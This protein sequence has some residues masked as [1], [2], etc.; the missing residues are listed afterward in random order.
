MQT[1]LCCNIEGLMVRKKRHKIKMIEE[2]G[3]EYNT[4]VICITESHLRNNIQDAEVTIQGYES[5][6]AD[7]IEG[8]KKGGVIVYIRK[9]IAESAIMLVAGSN[10]EVEYVIV[11]IKVWNMI[12]ATVYRPPRCSTNNMLEVIRIIETEVRKLGNPE[13]TIVINGDFNLRTIQWNEQIIYG[14]TLGDRTQANA[15]FSMMENFMLKQMI[16]LPTRGRS[17]LDIFLTNNEDIISNTRVEDTEISDHRLVVL[18][19]TLRVGRS[20]KKPATSVDNYRSLNFFH[21]GIDWE[22]INREIRNTDWHKEMEGKTSNDMYQLF[23]TRILNICLANIPKKKQP[24]RYSIPRDRRILIRKRTKMNRRLQERGDNATKQKLAG[25]ERDMAKSYQK[26]AETEEQKAVSN[27]RRNPKYFFKYAKKKACTHT[28]IGPLNYNGSLTSDPQIMSEALN[29]QY[30][31]TFSGATGEPVNQWSTTTPPTHTQTNDVNFERTDIE[32]AIKEINMYAA[33][34]P[35]GVPPVLL[36][37]SAST[38]S[39]PLHMIWRKSLDTGEI[40]KLLKHGLITPI[41]KSGPK[42]EPKNYRPVALTSHIIKI[43]ER[44]LVKQLT[45]YLSEHSLYN[46]GQHGFRSGRSCVSQLL[47]HRMN[48][49]RALEE[50]EGADVIYLDFSKAFDK[51]KHSILMKKLEHIGI[52]GN[53]HKWIENFFTERS[54]SVIVEGCQSKQS[55]VRSGVAQGSVIG[56]LLFLIYIS[57]IDHTIQYC[58]TTSFADDTRLMGIIRSEEDYGRIR[59]DLKTICSWAEANSMTFNSSKFELLRYRSYTNEIDNE[60]YTTPEG[61]VIVQKKQTR[62]LGVTVSDDACFDQQITDIVAKARKNMGWI[63]RTFRTREETALVTLYKTLILPR[64]EYCCQLWSPMNIGQI[65]KLEAV[66]RTFTARIEG[67]TNKNYW[68]RLKHLDM[69][70]LERRRERYIVIYV[71]KIITKMVP[72]LEDEDAIK[73]TTNSRKGKL[74]IIP[75]LARTRRSIQTLKEGSLAVHGPRLYNCL[76]QDLREHTGTL[77]SFKSGLDK[78]LRTVPDQP[79][80]PH[81]YQTTQGNSLIH[82]TRIRIY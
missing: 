28:N 24:K 18:E 40:P 14:E 81:Y 30:V 39:I 49:L 59:E 52:R 62:D 73:T 82:Q 79:S 56:P 76:P 20:A 66:Q 35:D 77:Y 10:G 17:I 46:E 36:K 50:G 34:G 16:H 1:I 71:W 33:A 12:L 68:E 21:D 8:R 44:I 72:N 11:H 53:I 63:L 57:D 15:L 42:T 13:P 54:Q 43:F 22:K 26:E 9:D 60:Q 41:Y 47:Q 80:L 74:C 65:R 37:Q 2:I 31:S 51:V 4:A 67:L 3:Y 61:G 25:I 58:T 55:L 78:Y 75:R 29:E 48:I 5:F 6:R 45:N 69:Y 19:T 70:S 64:V 32:E 23:N 38:L 7:R 27:I